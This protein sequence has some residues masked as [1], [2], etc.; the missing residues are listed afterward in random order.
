MQNNLTTVNVISPTAQALDAPNRQFGT[1]LAEMARRGQSTLR[2]GL[3]SVEQQ[4]EKRLPAAAKQ[5]GTSFRYCGAYAFNSSFSALRGAPATI[6]ITDR[7]GTVE[8]RALNNG[9]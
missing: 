4:L 3:V 2:S 9:N 1:R 7:D 6:T 8:T 5:R